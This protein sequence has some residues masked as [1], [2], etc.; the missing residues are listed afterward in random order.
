MKLFQLLITTLLFLS[1]IRSSSQ[2][3]TLT[4][5]K[6]YNPEGREI[7]YDEL[8]K[9]ASESDVFLF[10]ELHNDALIHWIQ[11]RL[12][13]DL[14]ERGEITLG[15]EFFELDDQVALQEY[16]DGILPQKNL[17]DEIHLWPNYDTDYA[18]IVNLAK[19]SG[20]TFVATNVPR[21]YAG[22]VAKSGLDTLEYLSSTRTS[23]T[24]FYGNTGLF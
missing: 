18:P 3:K 16:M 5:F 1:A 7:Q 11:Y 20:F 24:L 10:G 17:G 22:F 2:E 23:N 6:L 4:P 19:D 13:S 12:I 21:R 15:A 14:S 9:T 8:L